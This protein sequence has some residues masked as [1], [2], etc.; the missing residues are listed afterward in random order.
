[1]EAH[2]LRRF[3]PLDRFLSGQPPRVHETKRTV[4]EIRVP[5]LHILA[6]SGWTDARHFA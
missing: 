4:P 3:V 5:P 6:L 1:M 2:A